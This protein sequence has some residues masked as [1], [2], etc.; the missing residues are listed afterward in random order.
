MGVALFMAGTV[1]VAGHAKE[2][3]I[4]ARNQN[5]SSPR[6]VKQRLMADEYVT[7]VARV[8]VAGTC[9]PRARH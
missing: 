8:A 5:V 3:L 9:R 4:K 2:K 6:V 7:F 1:S